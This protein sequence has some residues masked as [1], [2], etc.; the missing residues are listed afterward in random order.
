MSRI[1]HVHRD[2]EMGESYVLDD[3]GFPIYRRHDC[4]RCGTTWTTRP[5][6]TQFGWLVTEHCPAC[7]PDGTVW[8]YPCFT[9][10]GMPYHIGFA[11]YQTQMHV[12]HER[13]RK[14]D[15]R[16]RKRK[17]RIVKADAYDIH[18]HI[19]RHGAFEISPRV[20]KWDGSKYPDGRI[21]LSVRLRNKRRMVRG[22]AKIEVVDEL[23]YI[24]FTP[25]NFDKAH[26]AVYGVPMPTA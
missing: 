26:R 10:Q 4:Q 17:T 13:N 15:T 21:T 16:K 3:F 25:N 12:E 1:K 5:I 7:G 24:V 9:E 23:S 20:F 22:V 18:H 2:L 11:I 6:Y 14:A 19:F 8:T